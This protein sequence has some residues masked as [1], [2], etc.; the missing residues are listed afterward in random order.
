MLNLTSVIFQE[1]NPRP[2]T[3]VQ[4]A[5]PNHIEAALR[6]VHMRA[7]NLQLLIVILPDVSGHYGTCIFEKNC[8]T[9]KFCENKITCM[10]I[11]ETFF[12][13]FYGKS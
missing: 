3:E 11:W 4:S 6:D 10:L 13:Q 12:T 8:G 2:V 5:S 7:P 9:Y 1:F